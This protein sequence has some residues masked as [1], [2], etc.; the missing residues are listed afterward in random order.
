MFDLRKKL[1]VLL[2]DIQQNG[3]DYRDIEIYGMRFPDTVSNE[4]VADHLIANGV[5]YQ[6]Y[7]PKFFLHAS[8]GVSDEMLEALKSATIFSTTREETIIPIVPFRW[9]P[10]SERLPDEEFWE[11]QKRNGDENLEV[12]AMIKGARCSTTLLYNPEDG[13]YEMNR[14]GQTFYIVTHWMPLPEPP[15]VPN[16]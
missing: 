14:A 16:V 11:N 1:I 7:T 3:N 9:I 8:P 5:T 10:V 13:F 6:D 2:D 15:E 12:L 4:V